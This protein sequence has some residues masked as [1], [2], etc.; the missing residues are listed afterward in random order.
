M[1]VKVDMLNKFDVNRLLSLFRSHIYKSFP[2]SNRAYRVY[3]A[4]V[5]S[6]GTS[7]R[8]PSACLSSLRPEVAF[9]GAIG[10]FFAGGVVTSGRGFDEA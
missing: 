3:I 5:Q 6:L 4:K 10:P 2:I 7:Y 8:R 9:I 1:G